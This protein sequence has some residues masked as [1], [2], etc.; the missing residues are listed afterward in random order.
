MENTIILK[1]NDNFIMEGEYSDV[2]VLRSSCRWSVGINKKEDS[3][4]QA[5]KKLIQQ[6]EHY[7]YIENQFFVSKPFDEKDEEDAEDIEKCKHKKLLSNL[8]QNTI[9]YEIKKRI[10]RAHKENKKFRV[11]VFLPFLPRFPGEPKTSGEIQL[12]L[13]YT[14]QAICRNYK[15]SIIEKLEKE[16]G[17]KWKDYIGFYS[18]RGHGLVN[19]IPKTELIYIHSKLMIVDDK[20]V[21]IGSANIN[22]RSMLGDRDSEFCVLIHEK[23]IENENFIIDG[24]KTKAANFAHSFRTHLMAEHL[25]LDINKENDKNILNDPLSNDLWSLLI[26]RARNNNI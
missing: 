21:I 8:I 7:I 11:I 14:Y 26:N 10:L 2:Q 9:A 12:I 25:G 16:I 24:Q 3:I 5:Y 20:Q 18:L 1:D 19:G 13:R 6:A 23:E 22:D 15:T 4:L 17:E